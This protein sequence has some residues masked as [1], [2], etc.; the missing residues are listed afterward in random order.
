MAE[1]QAQAVG[2]NPVDCQTAGWGNK[3]WLCPHI[4]G[5]D[6]AGVTVEAGLDIQGWKTG[7][8]V[9]SHGNLAKL[10]GYAEDTIA[11]Q[12]ILAQVPDDIIFEDAAA[13]PCAGFTARQILSRKL[14]TNPGQTTHNSACS[15][16]HE[17]EITEI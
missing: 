5:L 8:R 6:I 4:I 7:N 1:V 12:H 9:Y 10:G 14:K 15:C 11:P 3:A 17:T 13:L 2:L 16:Q